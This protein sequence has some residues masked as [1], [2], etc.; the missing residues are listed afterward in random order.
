FFGCGRP[1]LRCLCGLGFDFGAVKLDALSLAVAATLS[2]TV[3]TVNILYDKRELDT[4]PGRLTLGIL[5][6]QDVFAILFLALQPNLQHPAVGVL[7]L[8]LGKA[9]LLV[10]VTFMS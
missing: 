7:L 9:V 2:S 4:L 3:I 10:A 6:I 1:G 8:S 5:I